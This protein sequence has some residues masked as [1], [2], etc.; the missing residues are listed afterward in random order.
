MIRRILI[1][2][3]SKNEYIISPLDML[4]IDRYDSKSVGNIGN[5]LQAGPR[6]LSLF[7][8]TT[9]IHRPL[10]LSSCIKKEYLNTVSNWL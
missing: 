2:T 1:R 10:F 7:W 4:Q 3:L 8:F 9:T 6:N 5:E